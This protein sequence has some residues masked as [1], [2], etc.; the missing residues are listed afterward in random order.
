MNT[1][2]KSQ[3]PH[4]KAHGILD[5]HTQT[6]FW[7]TWFVWV[8]SEASHSWAL[9]GLI[10]QGSDGD[11]TRSAKQVGLANLQMGWETEPGFQQE[12]KL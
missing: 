8:D 5:S 10:A 6:G 2:A 12:G 11:G 3:R 1:V 4:N 9:Q 7:P